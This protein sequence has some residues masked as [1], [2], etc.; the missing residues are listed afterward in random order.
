MRHLA[1]NFV[2]LDFET[3]DNGRDSACA[4]GLVRV[5]A[6]HI[7]KRVYHLI[8]PPRP[9]VWFSHIHGLSWQ[10]V[11]D[12]P[13]FAQLWPQLAA[14]FMDIEFIAAHNASFDRG[15]LN[16]CCLAAG[17]QAPI[18]PYTCTVQLARQVWNIRPTKL[19]DVCQFLQIPLQ[20]H[21]AAS[22]A[23]ACARIVIAAQQSYAS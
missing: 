8:R 16:A 10:D 19:S 5:S 23:E 22:D 1:A 12:Q 3:A 14:E 2:A 9:R 18:L 17:V 6:G 21:H 20:H 7:V 4:I 13:T 11:K 15:V